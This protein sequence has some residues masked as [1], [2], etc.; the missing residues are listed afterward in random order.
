M[1]EAEDTPHKLLRAF[2]ANSPAQTESLQHSLERPVGG[3]GLHINADKTEY[4]SF[5]QRG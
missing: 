2:L 5:N 3:I 4:M 1:K